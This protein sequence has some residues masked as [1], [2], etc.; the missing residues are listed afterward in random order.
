MWGSSDVVNDHLVHLHREGCDL[1]KVGL[2]FDFRNPKKHLGVMSFLFPHNSLSPFFISYIIA[3]IMYCL[4]KQLSCCCAAKNQRLGVLIFFP[5]L[6]NVVVFMLLDIL[7][8][9][10]IF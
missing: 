7:I 9:S 1:E 5:S 10:S 4:Q 2:A 8:E 3:L 6:R